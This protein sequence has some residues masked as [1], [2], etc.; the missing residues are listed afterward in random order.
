[1]KPLKLDMPKFSSIPNLSLSL[2]NKCFPKLKPVGLG[3]S[4]AYSQVYPGSMCLFED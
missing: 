3:F 4:A 2:A 1:M